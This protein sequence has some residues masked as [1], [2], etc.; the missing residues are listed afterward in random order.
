MSCSLKTVLLTFISTHFLSASELTPCFFP[1]RC[2][3]MSPAAVLSNLRP[4][5]S[6]QYPEQEVLNWHVHPMFRT[7]VGAVAVAAA[8]KPICKEMAK[9]SAREKGQR[10]ALL[11]WD[12]GYRK[13]VRLHAMD[14]LELL[15]ITLLSPCFFSLCHFHSHWTSHFYSTFCPLY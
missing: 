3:C 9:V 5:A 15:F 4:T 14:G 13:T 10:T 6:S 1:G 11:P 7:L 2:T 12:L 8:T